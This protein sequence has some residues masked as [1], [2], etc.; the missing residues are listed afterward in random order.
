VVVRSRTRLLQTVDGDG[1]VDLLV[2]RPGVYT[3]ALVVPAADDTAEAL[4]AVASLAH[5]RRPSA[6]KTAVSAE[7]GP[8][9]A[10]ATTFAVPA[11]Q[12]RPLLEGHLLL[13]PTLRVRG[14]PLPL[15][16]INLLTVVPKWLGPL[17][18]WLP[19]LAPSARAGYNLVHYVPMQERGVS[20]S[21]YSIRDQL[22]I[23]PDLCP[24][25]TDSA[26]RE[27]ALADVVARAE[28]ELGLAALADVV[29]NHTA[30]DS[31]WLLEHPEAGPCPPA[32]SLCVCLYAATA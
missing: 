12:S 17:D 15:D 32:C 24:P 26:A 2:E 5:R 18:R 6:L 4:R 14:Q 28:K 21:P 11:R 16:G 19:Q 13:T 10:S 27:A 25:G 23:A 30:I 8:D 22:A 9:S 3:Y 20:N 7:A 1:F 31:P 29:W